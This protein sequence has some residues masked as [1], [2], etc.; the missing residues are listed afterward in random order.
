MAIG[1]SV[2]ADE[3]RDRGTSEE[4]EEAPVAHGGANRLRSKTD[5]SSQPKGRSG[6]LGKERLQA[7]RRDHGGV[8]PLEDGCDVVPHNGVFVH[9]K[10]LALGMKL[11]LPAFIHNILS[12]FR[13]AL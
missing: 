8:V 1:K 6:L 12:Y 7:V 4:G 5:A 11:L 2:A 9:P 13:V 3:S 10:I